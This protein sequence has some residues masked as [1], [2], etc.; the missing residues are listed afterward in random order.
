MFVTRDKEPR[1]QPRLSEAQMRIGRLFEVRFARFRALAPAGQFALTIL[2]V[3]SMAALLIAHHM[4]W[5]FIP[6]TISLIS[7]F[8]RLEYL[9][10]WAAKTAQY[11]SYITLAGTLVLAYAVM[12]YP[13]LSQQ[14]MS[15]L[16]LLEGLLL[17]AFALGFLF[18]GTVWRPGA[19]HSW[20]PKR[21]A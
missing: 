20:I 15:R 14:W 21:A 19:A 7:L 4:T 10:S 16:T 8:V 6:A 12:A 2:F 9:T 11:A 3:C 17:T 1:E 13:I 5:V 18:G